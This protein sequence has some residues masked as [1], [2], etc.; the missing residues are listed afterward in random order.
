MY[1]YC[2]SNLG[3]IYAFTLQ[4]QALHIIIFLKQDPQSSPKFS[5]SNVIKFMEITLLLLLSLSS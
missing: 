3:A 1:Q 4:K 2:Y 5:H